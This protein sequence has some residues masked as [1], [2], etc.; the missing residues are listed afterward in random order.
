MVKNRRSKETQLGVKVDHSKSKT[1]FLKEI[2]KDIT[3]SD[4]YLIK[5]KNIQT[6]VEI[7]RKCKLCKLLE[8]HILRPTYHKRKVMKFPQRGDRGVTVVKDTI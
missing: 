6:L 3:V 7:A 2:V 8:T 4:Y 1:D 5:P